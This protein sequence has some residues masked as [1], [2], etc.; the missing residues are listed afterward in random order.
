MPSPVTAAARI[1][2]A[3]W[4]GKEKLRDVLN[5]RAAVTGSTPRKRDV[6][7]R[8]QDR[9]LLRQDDQLEPAR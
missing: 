5:L 6:R 1:L 3:A 9:L 8:R 2:L 4:I 7:D